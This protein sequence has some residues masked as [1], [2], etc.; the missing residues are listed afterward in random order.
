VSKIQYVWIAR[1]N[2]T[3]QHVIR[4]TRLASS[5]AVVVVEC[6]R[7]IAVT[8]TRGWGQQESPER[9]CETCTR[10]TRARR[11][12]SNRN[13]RGS[14]ANRRARRVWLLVTFGDGVKA[15]CYRCGRLLDII[16]L[17]VDRII[18]GCQGGTYR[19]ANCRPACSPCNTETGGATRGTVAE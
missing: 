11:G 8:G 12:T 13:V 3:M 5:P 2:L 1:P 4:R 16:T 14:A 18:P 6:G 9:K 10:A 17:T 7:R 15:P 19:R